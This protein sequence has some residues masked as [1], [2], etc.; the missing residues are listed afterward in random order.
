M[1]QKRE[2]CLYCGQKMESKTA[3]KKFCTPLHRVYYNRELN[4]GAIT[5]V[6]VPCPV[7]AKA[8]VAL[9]NAENSGQFTKTHL[10]TKK[11]LEEI[12]RPQKSKLEEAIA[13]TAILKEIETIKS[14]KIPKERDTPMGRKAWQMDQQKRIQELQNKLNGI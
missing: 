5:E 10:M 2:T 12:N 4:R 14:E 1:I 11:Q 8:A 7:T 9:H 13:E 3:K 6:S